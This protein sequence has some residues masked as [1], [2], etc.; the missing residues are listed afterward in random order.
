[1]PNASPDI[2]NALDTSFWNNY[3]N[4]TALTPPP[5]PSGTGG[6]FLSTPPTTVP[7]MSNQITPLPPIATAP[8]SLSAGG[9]YSAPIN[10]SQ[11]IAQS[12][13]VLPN[14]GMTPEQYQAHLA[15]TMGT[16]L[17][18]NALGQ[19]QD[20]NNAFASP[21]FDN[22]TTT[23]LD[24]ISRI[25]DQNNPYMQNA[26]RRGLEQANSR[27]LLNS[28]IAAGTSQRAA[29]E[30]GM[31]IFNAAMN[32]EQQQQQQQWQAAQNARSMAG[33]FV[34]QNNQNTF[35][36]AQNLLNNANQMN[37]QREGMQFQGQQNDLN[38]TQ[39][40]NNALLGD[41][42]TKGQMGLQNS[43]NRQANAE[44]MANQFQVNQALNAQQQ[45]YNE[46][47][48][49]LN[50]QLQQSQ[51][52]N[53]TINQDWLA[54]NAFNRNLY[55]TIATLPVQSAASMYQLLAQHAMEEPDVYT[56]DVISGFTNFFSNDMRAMLQQYF[57]TGGNA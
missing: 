40:V 42:I 50:A 35:S 57:G 26:Y 54:S 28:S 43:L 6:G 11:Y 53:D 30:S 51:R 12:G 24:S 32:L 34:S 2:Q 5:A 56:P 19:V 9:S 23:S 29:I 8:I 16:G 13:G 7:S 48:A 47:S 46:R 55:G 18:T 22:A 36:S 20:I 27:G 1:M 38:R 37:S 15:S 33:N 14:N 45:G 17:N 25:M 49:A 3:Q 41:Q 21:T 31:P 44:N 10:G 52:Y 4:P 39:E